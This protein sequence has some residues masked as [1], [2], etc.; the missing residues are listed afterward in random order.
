M[1]VSSKAVFNI[2]SG[3]FLYQVR[4]FFC[5]K[6]VRFDNQVRLIFGITSDLV[7]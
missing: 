2:K 3:F 6:S 7:C 4:L 5:I 1:L